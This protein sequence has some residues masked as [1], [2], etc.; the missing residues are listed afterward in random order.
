MPDSDK[1][2]EFLDKL[3]PCIDKGELDACIYNSINFKKDINT[4]TYF[5]ISII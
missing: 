3:K 2:Q 5:K 4:L 1:I